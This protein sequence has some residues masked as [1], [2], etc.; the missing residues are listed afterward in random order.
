[1][2]NCNSLLNQPF[3]GAYSITV[4][5]GAKTVGDRIYLPDTPV[6]QDKYIV[7]IEAFWGSSGTIQDPDGNLVGNTAYLS[8]LSL[9]LCDLQNN[10]FLSDVSLD[11]F[12]HGGK[13]IAI[14]RQLFLPDCYLTTSQ[15]IPAGVNVLLTFYWAD[16]LDNRL[17]DLK[18]P[19]FQGVELPVYASAENRFYLPDNRVLVGKKIR[20]ILVS[21][22]NNVSP[23]GVSVIP[24][25]YAFLT[26]IYQNEIIL[27]R[28]PVEYL[29]Q[30]NSPFRLR[31]RDLKFDLPSSYIELSPSFTI[32]QGNNYALYM[33]FEYEP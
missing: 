6:L 29:N 18:N 10:G 21:N 15:A 25:G 19:W 32:S 28:Y 16:T 14:N 13:Q 33:N 9:T 12:R 7:A 24:V 30:Y 8:Q 5:I 23:S 31:M 11:Y 1:M 4:D 26:L 22:L 3:S 27:Y 17:E 20:N 2:N